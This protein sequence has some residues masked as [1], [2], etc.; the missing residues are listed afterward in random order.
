MSH[1]TYLPH[2]SICSEQN[3]YPNPDKFQISAACDAR[4]ILKS[5]GEGGLGM[6]ERG[7]GGGVREAEILPGSAAP[8]RLV[9]GPKMLP[10]LKLIL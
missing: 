10:G 7:L 1:N 3:I 9:H 5:T 6:R 4:D 8:R 2:K